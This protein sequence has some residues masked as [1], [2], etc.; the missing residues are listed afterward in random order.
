MRKNNL[1]FD[2]EESLRSSK[3][4]GWDLGECETYALPLKYGHHAHEFIGEETR[5]V[6]SFS[7]DWANMV[8]GLINKLV[9]EVAEK[10]KLELRFTLLESMVRQLKSRLQAFESHRTRLI[11]IETFTPEPYTALKTIL[12]SV[13]MIDDGFEAGWFDANI[14][15]S[16][17]NEEEAV[18][19]L[20]SLILDFYDSLSKEPVENLGPAVKRQLEV[21]KEFVRGSA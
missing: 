20:K 6:R 5:I 11:P 14:H 2:T 15:S 8:P 17:D 12:V 4:H 13:Q 7:E 9:V 10:K 18:V 1:L 19:N 21:L 3:N 16:G